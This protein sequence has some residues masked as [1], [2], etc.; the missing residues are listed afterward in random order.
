MY[1]SFAAVTRG[2][3][4]LA[5]LSKGTLSDLSHVLED[6]L[7]DSR[8]PGVVLTGF[9]VDGNWTSELTRYQHLE[10]PPAS[11]LRQEWFILVQ[12]EQFSCV[13][14]GV[15][16]PDPDVD[17]PIDEMDRLFDA[18]WTFEPDIIGELSDLVMQAARASDPASSD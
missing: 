17:M 13:L 1:D 10:L 3:V 12:A 2:R 5:R 11:G 6:V 14:F 15:D 9:Q 7:L 18:T 8:M 4:E 16:R